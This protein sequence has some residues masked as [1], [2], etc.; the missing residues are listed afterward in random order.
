MIAGDLFESRRIQLRLPSTVSA[1]QPLNAGRSHMKIGAHGALAEAEIQARYH[2]D[3]FEALYRW[4]EV[5]PAVLDVAGDAERAAALG[6]DQLGH[7]GPVGT[8]LVGELVL[9]T[10][11]GRLTGILELGSGFGGASRQLARLMRARGAAPAVLGVEL[12]AGHCRVATTIARVLGD[13]STTVVNADARR[14]PLGAEAVDAVV[15]VGSASHF[16][17]MD[18]VLRETRRVLRPDGVLVMTEEVS[19]RPAG[20]PP[21]GDAFRHH[22]PAAVF[23]ATTPE[24]RR[25]QLAAAGFAVET[26]QPLTG[27]ALPLVRQRVRALRFFAACAVQVFGGE[28]AFRSVTD[29]LRA[30]GDEYAR[31]SVEPT[32]IVARAAGRP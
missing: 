4:D 22:H 31:G 5:W 25:A 15:A 32:L 2:R 30:T 24:R 26:F 3:V 7:F 12:V 17:S 13:T 9:S 8:A 18:Q 14:L 21:V 16:S 19:L 23:P 28:A 29:T 1:S 10:V 11:R 6:L 27:W 20:A